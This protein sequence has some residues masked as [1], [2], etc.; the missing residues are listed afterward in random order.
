MVVAMKDVGRFLQEVQLELSKIV[1]PSL[2]ELVGLVVIVMILVCIF[3]VYIG[4][5]DVVF[6]KIAGQIF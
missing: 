6:Y 1:W 2:H 3:S 4:F 5:I